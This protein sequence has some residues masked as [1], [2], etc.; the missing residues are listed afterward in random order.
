MANKSEKMDGIIEPAATG[1]SEATAK[2]VRPPKPK[3]PLGRDAKVGLAVIGALLVIL[4]VVLVIRFRGD[5]DKDVAKA[6]A[7]ASKNDSKHEKGASKSEKSSAQPSPVKQPV[8]LSAKNGEGQFFDIENM[9]GGKKGPSRFDN[10]QPLGYG[11]AMSPAASSRSDDSAGTGKSKGNEVRLNAAQSGFD[12]PLPSNNLRSGGQPVE[13]AASPSAGALVPQSNT[14]AKT[15]AERGGAYNFGQTNTPADQNPANAPPFS[16][17]SSASGGG[18]GDP[19]RVGNAATVGGYGDDPS[20]SKDGGG[21]ALD[22][23][24]PTVGGGSRASDASL[25]SQPSTNGADV[26]DQSSGAPQQDPWSNLSSNPTDPIRSSGGAYDAGGLATSAS[27]GSLTKEKGLTDTTLES[28]KQFNP[29]P[30]R[31][32]TASATMDE[33]T[34][35]RGKM[36]FSPAATKASGASLTS[37]E[38]PAKLGQEP[39]PLHAEAGA[40]DRLYPVKQDDTYWTIAQEAYGSGAYFRALFQ[41]NQQHGAKTERLHNG[42]QLRLPDEAT[43]RRLYPELCPRQQRLASAA[44]ATRASAN[45]VD[46]RPYVVREGDTLYEIARRE[47]G[48]STRWAEIY[49]LNRDAIGGVTAPL[50]PQTTLVLPSEQ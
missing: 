24:A 9:Q 25:G 21:N 41:Y 40:T 29:L 28:V 8:A 39:A 32:S 48:K 34:S 7:A 18:I 23:P 20:T 26:A 37:R 49:E 12:S 10:Q 15:G 6:G 43:L 45:L 47:L 27:S 22:P 30:S 16:G 31:E 3:R 2:P 19:F 36:E 5:S 13:P 38:Q 17:N 42:V 35:R 11:G 1:E 44:R 46:G 14:A 33:P 50:E 4:V